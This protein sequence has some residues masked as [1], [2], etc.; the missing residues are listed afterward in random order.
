MSDL[1]K[2]GGRG[3]REVKFLS[4]I[5]KLLLTVGKSINILPTPL[6]AL[7]K[8]NIFTLKESHMLI[9]DS[10]WRHFRHYNSL[11]LVTPTRVLWALGPGPFLVSVFFSYQTHKQ[12]CRVSR[13]VWGVFCSNVCLERDFYYDWHLLWHLRAGCGTYCFVGKGTSNLF[14]KFVKGGKTMH[15]MKDVFLMQFLRQWVNFCPFL[16]K[17]EV[18]PFLLHAPSSSGQH[19]VRPEL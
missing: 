14:K 2:C 17:W 5:T 13:H 3:L 18:C 9:T 15:D 12:H 7:E 11:T 19:W 4:E 8:S 10:H 6:H 1:I 16:L